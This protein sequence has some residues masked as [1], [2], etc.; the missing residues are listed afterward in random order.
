MGQRRE[1]DP[2]VVVQIQPETVLP[3][4]EGQPPPG[5]ALILV[6][7]KYGVGAGVD[8]LLHVGRAEDE[9]VR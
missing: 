4:A 7:D 5:E 1:L 9:V 3:E 6:E 2:A 8:P